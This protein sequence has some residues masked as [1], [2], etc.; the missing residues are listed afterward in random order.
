LRN[1][2]FNNIKDKK[3]ETSPGGLFGDILIFKIIES[4]A[5]AGR[6]AYLSKT[7]FIT[8]KLKSVIVEKGRELGLVF[9]VTPSKSQYSEQIKAIFTTW[10]DS[11]R[12][13]GLDSW[14]L[15]NASETDSGRM[16]MCNYAAAIAVTMDSLKLYAPELRLRLFNWYVNHLEMVLSEQYRGVIS[17]IWCQQSDLKDIEFWCRQKGIKP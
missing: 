4:A 11:F 9:L 10:V 2:T 7:L 15:A 13:G 8:D 17:K 16:L 6:P 12:T 14:R 5:I 1:S 3:S